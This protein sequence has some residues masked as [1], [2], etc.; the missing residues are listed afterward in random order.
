M[1]LLIIATISVVI[2][3]YYRDKQRKAFITSFEAPDYATALI[4]KRSGFTDYSTLLKAEKVAE[5]LILTAN[6]SYYQGEYRKAIQLYEQAL[7]VFEHTQND[8]LIANMVFKIAHIH[9]ELQELTANSLVLKLLPQRPVTIPVV[10][11]VDHMLH[12]LVAEAEKN[13]GTANE[14]WDAALGYTEVNSEFQLICQGAIID[15]DVKNWLNNPDTTT[16]E[17]LLARLDE[18]QEACR[19]TQQFA[20]LCQAYLLQARISFVLVQ[21]EKMETWLDRCL[22]I[23]DEN[24][25]K[26][27]MELIQK[28]KNIFLQHRDQISSL[29]E[30]ERAVSPE[31]KMQLLQDYLKNALELV[32]PQKKK[33]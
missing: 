15:L 29:L 31:E 2:F 24:E 18:W 12:A 28:E 7:T 20:Y 17:S 32:D 25:L 23:A 27:F 19:V 14:A 11:A 10:E 33:N 8:S 5:V 3:L 13:W 30:A 4:I 22:Q 26:I 1:L 16:S 9:K 21:F 6:S